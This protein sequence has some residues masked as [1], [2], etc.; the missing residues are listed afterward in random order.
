MQTLQPTISGDRPFSFRYQFADQWYDL[1][2]PDQTNTP[3]TVRFQ[4][5]RQDFHINLE[6]TK[7]QQVTL[8]FARANGKTFE[9]LVTQLDFAEDG[10]GGPVGG[11]ASSIDG[12]IST[13]S[14]NTSKRRSRRL[15]RDNGEITFWRAE[16]GS[17]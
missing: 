16:A 14:R 15:G 5:S 17:T 7:I 12:L 6:Q 3:M 11:G 2:N 8:Y 13:R 1:H 10:A 9:V 4:T